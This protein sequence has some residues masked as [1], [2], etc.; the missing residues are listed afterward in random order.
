MMLT[1]FNAKQLFLSKKLFPDKIQEA[2][3]L[4]V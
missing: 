4:K 2:K 1:N 3:P